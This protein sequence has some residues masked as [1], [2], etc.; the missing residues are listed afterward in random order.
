MA[1]EKQLLTVRMYRGI[2]GD[3]FLL[4]YQSGGRIRHALIDCGVLQG[5]AGGATRIREIARNIAETC[6]GILDLL[7]VTHEHADHLSGFAQAAS[8]FF[9][10]LEISELWLAWTENPADNVAQTLR[11]K[12]GLAKLALEHVQP[13][14]TDG[15]TAGHETLRSLAKFVGID[16]LDQ[17]NQA[18]LQDFLP[19]RQSD[20]MAATEVTGQRMTGKEVLAALQRKARKVK[21]LS[22]GMVHSPDWN[23]ANEVPLRTYVLGPPR[24]ENKLKER[25]LG[26]AAHDD[27]IYLVT[28]QDARSLL[29]MKVEESDVGSAGSYASVSPF[30]NR[31][32]GTSLDTAIESD[33]LKEHYG[34]GDKR[35]ID[36]LWLGG[37]EALALKLD[38]DT[39]NTSLVL[40]F[41]LDNGDVALFAADAQVGNWLSWS[42]QTYPASPPGSNVPAEA[43][44]T[45]EELL[46]RVVL[47]KVGH[48]ASHN[49]TLKARGL[50]LMTSPDLCAMIPLVEEVARKQ[51][52]KGWDMPDAQLYE[53][54]V[55]KT[56]G[57]IVRGDHVP[58]KEPFRKSKLALN[59]NNQDNYVE[60]KLAAP[61]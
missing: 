18:V 36:D 23:D 32:R 19:A 56:V 25:G 42:D 59:F 11:A 45:V 47:Y 22:P 33:F 27:A 38:N 54:L 35:R 58:P 10:E 51:G 12:M 44:K 26:K 52:S 60:L 15:D 43:G 40:A 29:S 6:N 46:S 37:A 7:V 30:D 50:E 5:T 13:L 20:Q 34:P 24:S 9:G 17:Y 14:A 49:A 4:R 41:E 21:Y 39:N 53:A 48:H 28:S 57:R 31:F 1:D 2:L 3:C 61:Y 8:V 16:R 55:T